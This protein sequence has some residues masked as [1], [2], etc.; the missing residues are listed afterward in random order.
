MCRVMS[1]FQVWEVANPFLML[2][3]SIL[4]ILYMQPLSKRPP[5]HFHHAVLKSILPREWQISI[6][7]SLMRVDKFLYLFHE[8]LF[9]LAASEASLG[10]VKFQGHN[11]VGAAAVVADLPTGLKLNFWSR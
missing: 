7:A 6:L 9:K 10:R 11:Q 2:R 8:F 4:M 1:R 3:D 5:T